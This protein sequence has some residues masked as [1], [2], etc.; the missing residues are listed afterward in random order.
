MVAGNRILANVILWQWPQFT[1][2]ITNLLALGC[3]QSH[4]VQTDESYKLPVGC[5]PQHLTV[6][7][8]HTVPPDLQKGY[9][10]IS[11]SC[12]PSKETAPL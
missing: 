4:R 2:I 1:L 6:R 10:T 9:Y 12:S 8:K 3:E 5:L 7:R 11:R